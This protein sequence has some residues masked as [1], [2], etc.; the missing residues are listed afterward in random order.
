MCQLNLDAYQGR[1]S[2][3]FKKNF[4]VPIIFFTQLLGVALGLSFEELGIGK[5]IVAAGPVIKAKLAAQ[6][7]SADA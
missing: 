3:H 6:A 4:R 5:E 2:G 7:A 1:V